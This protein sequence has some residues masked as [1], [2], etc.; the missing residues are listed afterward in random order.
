[1]TKRKWTKGQTTIYK[2]LHRKPKIEQHE[3]HQKLRENQG[4]PDGTRHTSQ[5]LTRW[6]VTNEERI[7]K[8]SWPMATR[9]T[10]NQ[11][12]PTKPWRWPQNPQSDDPNSTNRNLWFSSSSASSNPP[13]RKPWQEPHVLE[14]RINREACIPHAGATVTQLHINGKPTMLKPK[15]CYSPDA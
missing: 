12:L 1:M 9:D 2:T 7:G 6:Q 4:V 10:D 3:P 15:R 5:P 11:Q 13:S 14:H 8:R